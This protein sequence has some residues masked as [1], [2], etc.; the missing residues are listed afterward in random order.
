MVTMSMV[1]D[2]TAE[3]L[4]DNLSALA[5]IVL[6]AVFVP[7]G[8][9]GSVM[10]LMG[11][12]G[13]AGDWALGIVLLALALVT[14][15]GGLAVTA[16][17]IDPPAGRTAAMRTATARLPPVLGIGLVVLAAMI[18]ATLP[19]GIA[20]VL[21]GMD[22]TAMAGGR[23]SPG[24]VAPGAALF[25]GLYLVLL[26]VVLFWLG[27]RLLL[28]RPVMILERRGLGVFAR[29]F[30]LTRGIAWKIVGL[31]LLYAI[32]S[33]VATTAAKT[34]SG[35]IF[36]LLIGGEGRATPAG[37]LTQVVAAGVSSIFS[38]LA[39]TFM[40]KLYLAARDAR[41]AIIEGAIVGRA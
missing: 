19:A 23:S 8:L 20:L 7:L 41:E 12:G 10:P 33:W 27:A 30:A 31:L 32:V 1:W 18:A 11:G 25:A 9:F 2:R 40:A 17:A 6:F 3:F 14:V 26:A 35:S 34:V 29:S 5:P 37:V 38:V 13:R 21:G 15:W 28:V 39:V 36:A 22:M 24:D 4:G 16:L